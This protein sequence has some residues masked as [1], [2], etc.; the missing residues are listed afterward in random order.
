VLHPVLARKPISCFR[1]RILHGDQTDPRVRSQR[2]RVV[3]RDRAGSAYPHT[4]GRV[5]A[6]CA[7]RARS[8]WR[9]VSAPRSTQACLMPRAGPGT[10]GRRAGRGRTC[11]SRTGTSG[12]SP[13]SAGVTVRATQTRTET[14]GTDGGVPR[15]ELAQHRE[16]AGVVRP[17]LL[18]V[19]LRWRFKVLPVPQVDRID[20]QLARPPITGAWPWADQTTFR[21]LVRKRRCCRSSLRAS[22]RLPP[23]NTVLRVRAQE[24]QSLWDAIEPPAARPCCSQHS[25]RSRL[26]P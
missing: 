13:R 21:K 2:R 8:S 12:P 5:H 10:S 22:V 25:S 14:G 9:P 20:D 23:D 24:H 17:R 4:E 1:E 11:R 26:R 6:R 7:C 16:P 15:A 3:A 19:V 18:P